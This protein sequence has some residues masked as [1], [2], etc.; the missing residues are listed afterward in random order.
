MAKKTNSSLNNIS[1]FGSI[2]AYR[3][4]LPPKVYKA[5]GLATHYSAKSSTSAMYTSSNAFTSSRHITLKKGWSDFITSTAVFKSTSTFIQ[6]ESNTAEDIAEP[7]RQWMKDEK[8]QGSSKNEHT[9]GGTEKFSAWT[10]NT[11]PPKKN[12]DV[13]LIRFCEVGQH[14]LI[15]KY[16]INL[17]HN[18]RSVW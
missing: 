8:L 18:T 6:H 15:L 2:S 13:L 16:L 3:M 1:V 14:L 11:P 5:V 17:Y 10:R 12:P 4:T 7:D 9:W